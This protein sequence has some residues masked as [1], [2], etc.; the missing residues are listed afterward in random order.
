MLKKYLLEGPNAEP[1]QNSSF[2][3]SI[4]LLYSKFIPKTL[5][6][7]QV[8]RRKRAII[9]AFALFIKLFPLIYT[10]GDHERG[11]GLLCFWL[12]SLFYQIKGFEIFSMF[13]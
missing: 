11:T 7:C 10:L 2:I 13:P 6:F 5:R 3:L 8:V 1:Q 12:R 9:I 4:D